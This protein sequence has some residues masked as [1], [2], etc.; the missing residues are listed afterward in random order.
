[1]SKNKIKGLVLYDK[2]TEL[3]ALSFKNP[4]HNP[5]LT[6]AHLGLIDPGGAIS[7]ISFVANGKLLEEFKVFLSL[8]KARKS[9]P[10]FRITLEVVY[11]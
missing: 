9:K 5:S 1:M 10:K 4:E 7:N 6:V 11:E 8:W 2:L 3:G